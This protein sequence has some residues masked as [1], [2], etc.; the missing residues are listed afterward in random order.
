M[1]SIASLPRRIFLGRQGE[2]GSRALT[3][4]V[5]PWLT[6]N[7]NLTVSIVAIR[8]TEEE[9]YVPAG[10]SVSNGT[11]VWTP[12]ATDTAIAGTGMLMVRGTD[13]SERVI[14]STT[15]TYTVEASF[16]TDGYT[17][18]EPEESWLTRAEATLADML[19]Q[20]VSGSESFVVDWLEEN[21]TQETGYV[22]DA[23][24]TVTGAAADAKETGDR[25]S[26]VEEDYVT[27]E[28]LEEVKDQLDDQSGTIQEFENTGLVMVNGKLCVKVERS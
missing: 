27:S 6:Q 12:D 19:D 14:K 15:A 13:A 9:A 11:L 2:N 24:L 28:E 22:I 17:P 10:V 5:S 8:P 4:D 16:D 20:L 7:P 18:S 21:I 26:A 3:V 1:Y 23:S 25:L